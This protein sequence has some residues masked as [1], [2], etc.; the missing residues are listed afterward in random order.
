MGAILLPLMALWLASMPFEGLAFEVFAL[1]PQVLQGT[2]LLAIGLMSVAMVL[3]TRPVLFEPLLGGLDRMYRLHKW[4]GISALILAV[5]H[6]AWV[7][8]PKWLVGAGL[9][10][11]PA[12]VPAAPPANP[13]LRELHALRSV[14]EGIGEWAFYALVLLIALALLKRFPYHRF[15]QTHRLL[16]VAYLALAFHSAVLMQ[17]SNWTTPIGWVI[18]L[19]LLAGTA[20]ALTVLSGAVGRSRQAVAV[21]DTVALHPAQTVLAVAVRLKSRWRGHQAGQFAFVRFDASE[22]AHPFTITSPWTGDGRLEFLIKDLG[23]YTK[24]LPAQL[25]PGALLRVEGPYGTFDFEGGKQ[26]QIWVSG[27]IGITPFLARLHQLALRPDGKTVDLFHS[28]ATLDEAAFARLRVAADAADATL[29]LL[30]DAL[31]GRMTAERLCAAVPAWR[32]ADIWFCGPAGFGHS[33]R[34]DLL[35]TGLPARHFHQELFDLR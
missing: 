17:D 8:A 31:D 11:K 33:L 22:G 9:L 21:V 6:W 4:L 24:T 14:A 18:A 3:A 23:D 10:D 32:E 26:R 7:E 13:L 20:A 30:V 15:F 35:A 28:T 29:H 27:G 19:L 34:R 12:R 1:R 2:G 25:L 16:A 5:S